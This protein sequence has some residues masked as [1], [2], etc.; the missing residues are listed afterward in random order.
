MLVVVARPSIV[1]HHTPTGLVHASLNSHER[2]IAETWHVDICIASHDAG[3]PNSAVHVIIP[4]I[5]WIWHIIFDSLTPDAVCTS[6]STLLGNRFGRKLQRSY[7][8]RVNPETTMFHPTVNPNKWRIS[9]ASCSSK[10]YGCCDRHCPY[11][12]SI[13]IQFDALALGSL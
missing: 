10:T 12:A 4:L 13:R 8:N 6:R 5:F 7:F 11:L 1:L 3:T 2:L 9:Q